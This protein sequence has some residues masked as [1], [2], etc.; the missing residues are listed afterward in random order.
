MLRLF[1]LAA[2]AVITGVTASRKIA[3][4]KVAKKKTE[5]VDEVAALTRLEIQREAHHYIMISCRR[6]AIG[7]LI[8]IAIVFTLAMLHLYAFIGDT[9]F[10][11]IT[12][13]VLAFL[14]ARDLI[15]GWPTMKLGIAEIRKHGLSAK[16]IVSEM[17]AAQVFDRVLHEASNQ[18]LST[19]Q[20]FGLHLAG[21]TQDGFSRQVATAVSDVARDTSWR[22]L[23]PFVVWAVI[24]VAT[25]GIFYSAVIAVALRL[26]Q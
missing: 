12:S 14:L 17:V 1:L 23:R 10:I 5:V 19:M 3:A 13:A 11:I 16:T 21:E 6:Y 25:L 18:K 8:K 20:T 7:L 9:P 26:S 2:S 22:D 24:S 15:K 4:Q